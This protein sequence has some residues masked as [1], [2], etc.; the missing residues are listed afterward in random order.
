VIDGIKVERLQDISEEDARAEGVAFT[1]YLNANARY[2]F[3][4]L[5]NSIYKKKGQGWDKNPWNWCFKLKK[6]G[7]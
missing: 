1:K 5:W 6:K 7:D 4:E 3:M 2:H